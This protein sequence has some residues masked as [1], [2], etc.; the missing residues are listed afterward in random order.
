MWFF[1]ARFHRHEPVAQYAYIWRPVIPTRWLCIYAD[2]PAVTK[3]S[4][5]SW[6]QPW[7]RFTF[8][9]SG[10]AAGKVSHDLKYLPTVRR[11]DFGDYQGRRGPSSP[12]FVILTASSLTSLSRAFRATT[13]PALVFVCA[14]SLPTTG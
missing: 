7:S 4:W 8:A 11:K 13:T 9:E 6:E 10:S 2:N 14:R 12:Q 3:A 1:R 5:P